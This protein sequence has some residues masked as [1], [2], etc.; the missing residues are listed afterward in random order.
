MSKYSMLLGNYVC[1]PSKG[2]E[3]IK[4]N[5]LIK[6]LQKYPSPHREL[7]I[8]IMTYIS[9]GYEVK[10]YFAVPIGEKEFPAL[11][12]LRGGIK[13]VGMVRLSRVIEFASQG[14]IVLAPFYRGNKGGE[15]REDFAGDD[16]NDAISAYRVLYDHPRVKRNAVHLFGFSRGGVMALLTATKVKNPASVVTWGGV[17]DMVLTYEER[18]DLRRMMKRVIGGT[19]KKV[20]EEYER[21]TVLRKVDQLTCPVL[22]VHGKHD[23]QVSV[24]HAYRLQKALAKEKK[25]FE[26]WIYEEYGHHIPI[27]KKRKITKQ[28]INWMKMHE[29]V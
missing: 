18:I 28:V 29:K 17:S 4:F 19:P 23:T 8:F 24:D 5:R 13:N 12:Y 10:A 2:E 14:F 25:V 11:L 20:P 22:I 21:R 26:S 1:M 27:E 9:E 15:G 3:M 7:E 16:I 6:K